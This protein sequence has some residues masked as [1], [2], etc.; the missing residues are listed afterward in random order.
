MKVLVLGASPKSGQTQGN[1]Y[2]VWLSEY[3]GE[4]LIERLVRSCQSLGDVDLIFA[5]RD[6]DVRQY[7]ID[8]V[9]KLMESQATIMTVK[10]DTKGAACTALL[11]IHLIDSD[12]E[13]L[14]LNANEFLDTNF[15][16]VVK[17]FRERGLDAGIVVFPSVHPRYSY[18]KLDADQ[19]VIESAEKNPISR[20]A[21]AGFYW[22]RRGRDFV[23]A[24][25][26]MIRKDAHVD[27]SFYICPSFNELVL[28]Q[29]RIGV[30]SVDSSCYHPLKSER[31]VQHYE[32]E[33]RSRTPL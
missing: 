10:G 22:Y 7:H 2:P 17:S 11:C 23:Q 28:A 8:N 9:I 26:E 13:L 14:I 16:N 5:I 12:E 15:N 27:G 3:R 24:A 20:N 29:A 6:E 1:N 21:T 25:K 31:Q 32:A 4:I 30:F 33:L 19:L 18:V